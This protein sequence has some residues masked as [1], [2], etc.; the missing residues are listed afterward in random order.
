[1]S[2][3]CTLADQKAIFIWGYIER[4]LASRTRGEIVPL[5]SLLVRLHMDY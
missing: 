4:V 2:Q 1:M 3:Q 5:Y